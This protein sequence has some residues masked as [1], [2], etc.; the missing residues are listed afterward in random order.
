MSDRQSS[1]PRIDF[2]LHQQAVII[3]RAVDRLGYVDTAAEKL[4]KVVAVGTSGLYQ[5][6]AV[7]VELGALVVE[8]ARVVAGVYG[9][10]CVHVVWVKADVVDIGGVPER[11]RMYYKTVERVSEL[12]EK[13][14]LV[15]MHE[16]FLV[17]LHPV[18]FHAVDEEIR[19]VNSKF[20]AEP[21]L[22]TDLI[23]DFLRVLI[24]EEVAVYAVLPGKV[25]RD[26][27]VCVKEVVGD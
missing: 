16:K 27:G 10:H 25:A 15:G 3:R 5:T 12:A 4:V 24:A 9:F 22:Q 26:C 8:L 13:D 18:L 7:G 19:I 6:V 1:F 20:T 23:A 17:C 21:H 11:V 14:A 2:S